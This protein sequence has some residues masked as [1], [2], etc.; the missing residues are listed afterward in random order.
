[1]KL[2]FALFCSMVFGQ[3]MKNLTLEEKKENHWKEHLKRIRMAQI[4]AS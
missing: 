2:K 4:S 3:K 1:M